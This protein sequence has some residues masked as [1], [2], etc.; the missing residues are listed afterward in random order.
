MRQGIPDVGV[1]I[2]IGF[3]IGIVTDHA[4]RNPTA[5]AIPTPS[6]LMR[7]GAPRAQ[8]RVPRN[9]GNQNDAE[10]GK[11]QVPSVGQDAPCGLELSLLLG[12]LD[13]TRLLY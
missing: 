11:S 6:T 4:G 9:Q 10:Y 3:A 7:I 5:I 2:G 13:G 8:E 12:F 1:G